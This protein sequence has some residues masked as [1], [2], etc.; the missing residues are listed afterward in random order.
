MIQPSPIDRLYI[1]FIATCPST[2][3]H[4]CPNAQEVVRTR[5]ISCTSTMTFVIEVRSVICGGTLQEPCVLRNTKRV[6][7]VEYFAAKKSDD[8][9]CRLLTGVS[10]R[11]GRQL[12]NT[13]VFDLI[14]SLRNAAIVNHL[15]P[16]AKE[17]L[18]V[19][20]GVQQ[21]PLKRTK[22]NVR[23]LPDY[24]AITLPPVGDVAGV[25]VRVLTCGPLF[26]ELNVT[27][28][29]WLVAAVPIMQKADCE[30][31]DV[32]K[33]ELPKF[34]S[35]D[36]SRQAYKVRCGGQQKWFSKSASSD[37][38]SDAV[39]YLATLPAAGLG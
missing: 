14:A 25:S 21:P 9:M 10:R 11:N 5:S 4:R 2:I 17:D 18:G 33:E 28:L 32:A 27:V 35:F 3:D 36:A 13:T 39:A 26:L 20:V 19:D 15:H 31:D 34:V 30:G 37:P 16:P 29:N 7:N 23:E 24:V 8:I 1:S 38:L 6:D 12:K 22:R